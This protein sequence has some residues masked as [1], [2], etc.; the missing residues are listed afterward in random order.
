MTGSELLTRHD[1]TAAS[2]LQQPLCR[3][4]VLRTMAMGGLAAA[5]LGTRPGVTPAAAQGTAAA[6]R[7]GALLTEATLRAFEADVQQAVQTFGIPGA[8]V[9]LVE[10]GRIV[11]NRGFGVRELESRAPVTPR[12]RFRI[13]SNTKSMTSLLVGTLIDE[14]LFG[15]DTPVVEIWPEF[16]APSAELT[17][18]LRVRDLMG[19]ASGIAESPTDEFFFSGGALSAVDALRAIAHLPVIA[20]PDTQYFYNNTLWAAAG[21]LGPLAQGTPLAELEAAYAALLQQRVFDPI[22]MVDAAVGADPRPLG[23]DW[24]GAYTH[25]LFGRLAGLTFVSINGWGP[26]G[27][28]IASA[29]DMARYLITQLKGGVTP[30]GTR[31][32]SAANLAETQRPGIGLRDL[33]PELLADTTDLRYAMGWVHQTFRDGRVLLWHS[34]GIEGAGSLM[35]LLPADD[36]GFVLLTNLEAAESFFFNLAVTYSL[37]SRLFGLNQDLPAL[38]AAVAAMDAQQRA[39]LAGQTRPVDPAAV[40]P[41]LG[42]YANGFR[43][44]LDMAGA[45]WLEHDIRSM[46]LLALA[47][48]GCVVTDGS[49]WVLGKRV[50]FATGVDGRPTMTIEGFEPVAWLTGG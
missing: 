19:N 43:L 41:Y 24:A 26:A 3:R 37:L 13:A 2:F 48:G 18:T 23:A 45:L 9:A 40:T 1:Q 25:D 32:V 50:T 34:G 44:R 16:R 8:A 11:Y 28:G 20:P 12:T 15:W 49:S 33:P 39:E 46:P 10:G 6:P 42:L 22:G 35:G 4:G 38:L 27:A 7:G 21:F 30:E 29:T 36:L 14:G 5:V 47:D 17:R 31:I